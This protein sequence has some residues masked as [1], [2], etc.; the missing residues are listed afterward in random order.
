MSIPFSM[1]VPLTSTLLCVLAMMY[2]IYRWRKQHA[3]WNASEAARLS[4]EDQLKA[5][6]ANAQAD[7]AEYE[8]RAKQSQLAE[9]KIKQNEERLHRIIDS[10]YDAFVVFDTRGKITTFSSRAIE[11]FGLEASEAIGKSIRSLLEYDHIIKD[12]SEGRP[13]DASNVASCGVV[14]SI[15][16]HSSGKTIPVEVSLSMSRFDRRPE[17]HAF[18][19]DLSA[20]HELQSR[21]MHL[22]KMESLGKLSAGLAHEINTPM[23]FI[24]DNLSFLKS[25]LDTLFPILSETREFLKETGHLVPER[26]QAISSLIQEADLEF[27]LENM[28]EAVESTVHGIEKIAQIT[29]AMK[30]FANPGFTSKSMANVDRMLQ[31]VV[32]VARHAWEKVAEL[33]LSLQCQDHLLECMPAELSQVFASMLLNACD[34]IQ[35][36]M[37][38]G[39]YSRGR[40]TIE[41]GV[42]DSNLCIHFRD[43]GMGIPESIRKKIF[44]PFF[45]TRDVGKGMGQGLTIA[46]AV[47]VEKHMGS[48]RFQTELHQ[49]T[50]FTISIPLQSE[51]GKA[52]PAFLETG[53][54]H[55]DS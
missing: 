34:T 2:S 41:T 43:D 22:E 35:E 4:L 47:V 54:G 9:Q 14:E 24:G 5:C 37:E 38:A 33:E 32:T 52:I 3:A 21:M 15:A 50:C 18:I 36:K 31:N 17:F 45:T 1:L 7:R 40:I 51:R 6:E 39:T 27:L 49:G 29:L 12:L 19:H 44:D 11:L 53:A 30:E 28:P 55:E 42:E 13:K 23:Q 48:I 26:S 20:R 10:A 16:K 46:H 8:M 25:S